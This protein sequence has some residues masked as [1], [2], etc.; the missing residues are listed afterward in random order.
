MPLVPARHYAPAYPGTTRPPGPSAKITQGART[1]R[2]DPPCNLARQIPSTIGIPRPRSPARPAG[3]SSPGP[4]GGTHP[5]A[6]PARPARRGAGAGLP[7]RGAVRGAVGES[8]ARRSGG[9]PSPACCRT[10]WS[11]AAR[12]RRPAGTRGGS[13]RSSRP[14]AWTQPTW[15]PSPPSGGR[16]LPRPG[17]DGPPAAAPHPRSA[18]RTALGWL[19]L[20]GCVPRCR[21][22]SVLPRPRRV[23]RARPADLR[24]VPGP[25]AVPGLRPQPR[26]CA[27]HLGRPVRAGPPRAKVPPPRCRPAGA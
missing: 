2:Q 11:A 3:N 26:H 6:P 16:G 15:P 8:P 22:R 12:G 4:R 21:P 23:G 13:R 1:L 14:A 19:A 20:P 10:P 18:S 7:D 17:G 25:A 9:W 5:A 27:R 24:A